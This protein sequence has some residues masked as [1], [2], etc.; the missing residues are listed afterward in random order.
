MRQAVL[1]PDRTG[2]RSG[3]LV[4]RAAGFDPLRA[5]GSLRAA[6]PE[7]RESRNTCGPRRNEKGGGQA[8]GR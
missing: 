6:C 8:T 7:F 3:F 5:G 1:G 2:I 4:A